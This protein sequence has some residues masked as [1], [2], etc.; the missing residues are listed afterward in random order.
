MNKKMF[1]KLS[2]VLAAS[3]VLTGAA[4]TASGLDGN[5]DHSYHAAAISNGTVTLKCEHCEGTT[6]VQ[7]DD[8]IN[9]D[10][11]PLD[12]VEDGIV[13]AKDYAYLTKN[14]NEFGRINGFDEEGTT[15]WEGPTVDL[16]F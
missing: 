11:A 10:Y 13:N 9:E 4:I 16:D 5:C 12:V 2:L 14:F 1:K 7:F 6:Q 8:Y 15:D 3:T